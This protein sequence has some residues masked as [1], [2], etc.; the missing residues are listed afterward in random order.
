MSI[1]KQARLVDT[2]KDGRWMYFRL[3][4]QEVTPAAQGAIDLVC[5]SL[6]ATKE[7]VADNRK[8]A[9][10]LKIDPEVIC[11]QQNKN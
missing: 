2:R 9:E 5:R 3:S 8:L 7:I 4:D 11:K 10:I 1:L 6:E